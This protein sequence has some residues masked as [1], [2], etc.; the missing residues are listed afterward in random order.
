MSDLNASLLSTLEQPVIKPSLVN[1]A[2][3]EG[4]L[5]LLYQS[6]QPEIG[7]PTSLAWEGKS[8]ELTALYKANAYRNL[9]LV[10][11]LLH[12]VGLFSQL[13]IP[14][15]AIKGPALAVQAYGDLS[16]RSFCDLDVLV[17][18]ADFPRVY[19]LLVRSGFTPQFPLDP[20]RQKWWARFDKE[21]PF[22]FHGETVEIHWQVA[23]RGMLY[24]LSNHLFWTDPQPVDLLGCPVLTLSPENAIF[25]ACLHGTIHEWSQ[26][27]WVADLAHL[28]HAFPSVDLL[29]LLD[30]A[31]HTGFHRLVCTALQL[32]EEP[33]GA[34]FPPDVRAAFLSDPQAGRLADIIRERRN[35]TRLAETGERAPVN[36]GFFVRTR[37]RPLDRLVYFLDRIFTPRQ[38]DW[39]LLRLPSALS[40]LYYL[41]RPFRLLSAY[42]PAYL[43]KI[44]KE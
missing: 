22:Q 21:F 37:E 38:A 10:T 7:P 39:E 27:K 1:C 9:H 41:I 3:N 40:P 29:K 19:A 32:A 18:P 12:L 30:R 17:N 6:V 15:L 34:A 8:S 36:T 43:W 44:F 5:P 4:I 33:G 2:L 31:R 11:S 24:P 25:Y 26:L 14:Y 20:A 23:D 28:C 42:R 13:G 16:L 35:P